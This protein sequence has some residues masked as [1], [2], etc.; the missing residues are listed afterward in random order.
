MTA[1]FHPLDTATVDDGGGGGPGPG[2]LSTSLRA[3]Q[4]FI[5]YLFVADYVQVLP[6]AA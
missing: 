2:A 4:N 1:A 3:F 6:S 5:P